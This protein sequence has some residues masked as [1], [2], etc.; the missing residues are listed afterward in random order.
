MGALEDINQQNPDHD[1][2][3]GSFSLGTDDDHSILEDESNTSSESDELE[4]DSTIQPNATVAKLSSSNLIY[5]VAKLSY[6]DFS[7]G[8]FTD[9]QE[10]PRQF[11][12]EPIVLLD[13]TTVSIESD[14]IV[15]Q[16]NI[17]R[18][19]IKMWTKE[20]RSKVLDR[21]R[22]LYYDVQL[23]DVSVMPYEELKLVVKPGSIIEQTA[24][25]VEETITYKRLSESIPFYF[26]CD[27]E[28]SAT[29][30]ADYLRQNTELT[31]ERCK[32][33]LICDGLGLSSRTI[34]PEKSSDRPRATFDVSTLPEEKDN[35]LFGIYFRISTI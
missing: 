9:N 8:I 3:D 33:A 1:S 26:I 4:I 6:R 16:N 22:F 24:R 18:L 29:I 10:D 17:V 12:F 20:L 32:L 28:D 19:K 2:S 31:L 14:H 23:D 11:F 34:S 35:K 15:K 25:L 13:P 21:L 5:Q 7:I 27:S 30:L